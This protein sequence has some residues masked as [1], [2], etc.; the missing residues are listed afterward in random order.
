[1][2]I[3]LLV[4]LSA[5]AGPDLK[6]VHFSG[7]IVSKQ[8]YK[9]KF[10]APKGHHFNQ[11][12]PAKVEIQNKD[13]AEAGQIAKTLQTVTVDFPKGAKVAGDCQVKAQLYVCDDANTYCLP[14]KQEYDCQNLKL[15]N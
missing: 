13:K 11:E 2:L 5:F 7:E 14:I 4:T 8:P 10:E 15:K 1:M 9:L 6:A 3:S 12:A